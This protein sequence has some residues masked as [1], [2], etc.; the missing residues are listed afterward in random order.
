ML[1]KPLSMQIVKG[2]FP[3]PVVIDIKVDPEAS[4]KPAADTDA[5]V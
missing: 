1:L 2:F 3:C 4:Y 5:L